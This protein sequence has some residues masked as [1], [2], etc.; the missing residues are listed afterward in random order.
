MAQKDHRQEIFDPKKLWTAEGSDRIQNED[1]T[2]CKTQAYGRTQEASCRAMRGAR[3]TDPR[4]LWIPDEV[5]CR[6]QEG[7]LSRNSGTA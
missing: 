2:L 5:G 6:L 4:N 1:Y 7:I 3:E